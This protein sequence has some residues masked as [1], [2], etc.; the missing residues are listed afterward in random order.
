MESVTR[1]VNRAIHRRNAHSVYHGLIEFI[2]LLAESRLDRRFDP[3]IGGVEVELDEY[4]TRH[5]S[6]SRL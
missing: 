3:K 1:D 5:L 6:R 4:L 2:S